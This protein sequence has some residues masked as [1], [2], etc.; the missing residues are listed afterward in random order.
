MSQGDGGDLAAF[1]LFV[2]AFGRGAGGHRGTNVFPEADVDDL[3]HGAQ[4]IPDV[5]T[6][7]RRRGEEVEF[8]A[9]GRRPYWK[10][11]DGSRAYQ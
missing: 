1:G 11:P 10:M 2:N 5:V 3:T 8:V 6:E 9:K 7:A 4:S